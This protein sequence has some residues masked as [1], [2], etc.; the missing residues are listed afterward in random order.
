[1]TDPRSTILACLAALRDANPTSA[2]RDDW[3]SLASSAPAGTDADEAAGRLAGVALVDLNAA[4]PSTSL[5]DLL[6]DGAGLTDLPAA[7]LAPPLAARL[8]ALS[9][10]SNGLQ[11]L[12]AGALARCA[13]LESL[14]A[15]GNILRALPP[16]VGLLVN[17]RKLV[18]AGNPLLSELPEALFGGGAGGRA[19]PP[20]EWL[21]ASECRLGALPARVGALAATLVRL[22]LYGNQLTTVPAELGLLTRLRHLSLHANALEELPDGMFGGPGPGG[23]QGAA[24]A[25]A[26]AAAA[27][28][29]QGR[30]GNNDDDDDPAAV[31][32]PPASS[33]S[34]PLEWL[35]LNSN[36]LRS[37]PEAVG[38]CSRLS[39][40]SLHINDLASL[41]DPLGR[42]ARLEALSLH[43]NPRLAALPS[44]IGGLALCTRLS[45]YETA[46]ES[47]PPEIGGMSSLQELWLYD[48]RLSCL[49]E[50]IG[51]CTALRRLWVDRNPLLASLPG[52]A[53]GGLPHLQE[54]YADHCPA[55][56]RVPAELAR[57]GATLRRLYVDLDGGA[58]VPEEVR[59]L[60]ALAAAREYCDAGGGVGGG[61]A[62]PPAMAEAA[63]VAAAEAFKLEAARR[64]E[65]RGS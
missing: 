32:H 21:D 27:T 10:A 59:R 63:E 46:L 57:L 52:A 53:L 50:E 60:P 44:S 16:E 3:A 55:L 31:P 49:P 18:V 35:S 19:P 24:A 48:T 17:L 9:L 2:L 34:S 22:D 6:L 14:L 65:Q 13:A 62:G 8:R 1:M 28:G 11:S 39:R 23:G 4:A 29:L 25:A 30:G 33:S 47:L 12:P 37:L 43:K 20:L 5:V 58:D 41:P 51:A 56:R 42:C 54:L 36:K 45:L 61:G 40:L 7:A 15:G 26:E 64:T 38:R